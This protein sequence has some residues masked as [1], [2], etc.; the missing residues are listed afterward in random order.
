MVCGAGPFVLEDF[1]AARSL[2]RL[3]LHVGVVVDGR[4]ASISV[5]HGNQFETSNLKHSSPLF[6]GLFRM[7]QVLLFLQ[8]SREPVH[9]VGP[10][11]CLYA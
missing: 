11:S 1:L 2:Q 5:F 7:L 8:H 6:Y 3:Q 4:D 9:S 10:E